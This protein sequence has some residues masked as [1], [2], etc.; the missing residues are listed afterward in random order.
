MMYERLK[1]EAKKSEG[2]FNSCELDLI[3]GIRG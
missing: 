2:F 3:R 1:R